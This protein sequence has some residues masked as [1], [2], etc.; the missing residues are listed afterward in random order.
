MVISLGVSRLPSTEYEV[1]DDA[2]LF[3]SSINVFS[4]VCLQV[5]YV[6][7]GPLDVVNGGNGYNS[8]C[9]CYRCCV[10]VVYLHE[11]LLWL[12]FPPTRPLSLTKTPV[13]QVFIFMSY[14]SPCKTLDVTIYTVWLPVANWLATSCQPIGKLVATRWR[15]VGNWSP[16]EDS[17][18][19]KYP[20][21]LLHKMYLFVDNTCRQPSLYLDLL[22]QKIW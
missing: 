15:L 16:K 22:R 19:P 21:Q 20:T 11:L 14:E 4:Y 5:K 8:S 3:I 7:R 12:L 13:P 2:N 6:G 10:V 1:L 17:N 18:I 9:C